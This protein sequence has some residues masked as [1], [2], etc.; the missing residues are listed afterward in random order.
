MRCT[1]S[2]NEFR[3]WEGRREGVKKEV[4]INTLY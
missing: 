3:E 1:G 2:G 4:E